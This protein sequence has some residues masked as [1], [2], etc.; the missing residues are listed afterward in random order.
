M[1]EQHPGSGATPPWWP[2]WCKRIVLVAPRYPEVSGGSRYIDNLAEALA[3]VGVSTDVVSIYPGTSTPLRSVTTVIAREPLHRNP[4]LRTSAPLW[5]RAV[6]LPLLGFKYLDRLHLRGAIR[7]RMRRYGDDT[8]V[9]FTHV[10]AKQALDRAGVD[11]ASLRACLVGQHHSAFQSLESEPGLE[12]ALRE[13][14]ADVDVFTALSEADAAKFATLMSVPCFSVANMLS[15]SFERSER[16]NDAPP[17]V[18]VALARLTEE[19]Q[20]D[21]MIRAFVQ[22]TSSDELR[23]WSLHIYGEGYQRPL[24]ESTIA[25]LGA[26]NRVQLQGATS[27]VVGVLSRASVHLV[28]SRYEGFGLS[29]LEAAQGGVMTLA[30]D[31]SPG[32]HQLMLDVDGVLV[33]PDGGEAAMVRTIRLVLSDPA[34]IRARG[35]RARSGAQAYAP[36][37]IL[38]DWSAILDSAR[39]GAVTRL[40]RVGG[41]D[42][43]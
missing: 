37:V 28:T 6:K 36:N 18:A 31:C 38:Q 8:A 27:D 39:R 34:G 29:V 22:A 2:T 12:S 41:I 4:V 17:A 15:P 9:I 16:A 26:Q 23:Q 43:T 25:S 20:L 1:S 21:L 3:E 11:S 35:D 40:R 5:R 14:F 30:F 24:L 19:K 33:S 32:L 42:S 13:S 10:L 7:R